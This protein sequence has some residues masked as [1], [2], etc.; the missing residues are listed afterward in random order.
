MITN[1]LDERWA[2]QH[3]L[4]LSGSGQA[5]TYLAGAVCGIICGVVFFCIGKLFSHTKAGRSRKSLRSDQY[6]EGGG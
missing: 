5:F 6:P 1:A 2:T 3:G 4:V